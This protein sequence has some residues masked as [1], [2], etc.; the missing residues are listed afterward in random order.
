MFVRDQF[1]NDSVKVCADPVPK[2]VLNLSKP[3][4]TVNPAASG[5]IVNFTPPNSGTFDAIEVVEYESTE[6]NE[7]QNS[8]YS[9]VY[10]GNSN[11]IPVVTPNYSPRWVKARF[12]TRG[13]GSTEYS[14]TVKVTPV[15]PIQVR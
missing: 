6:T 9:R 7:P 11:P 10:F 15:S 14:L 2:Y 12:T 3:T 13:G 1:Y 8:K 4:I 5:Y